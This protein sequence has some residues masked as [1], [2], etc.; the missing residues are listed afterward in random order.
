MEIIADNAL[1]YILTTCEGREH[2]AANIKAQIPEAIVN[3]DDFNDSGKFTSTA[4]FNYQRGWKLAGDSPCVQMDDDI[5]LTSNFKEKI[6]AV[7][8]KYPNDIIQFFSMRKKDI[9]IGT[10]METLSNFM[11]QQCYYLPCGVAAKI[12]EF[13]REF[14]EY[15]E[16]RFCPSDFVISDWGK[17]NKR[18]Y[19]IY[20]PNLVDHMDTVSKIDKRRS[21]KR[22]SKTFKK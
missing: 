14:Y 3:F 16:D 13:S 5:I 19:V 6:T 17:R 2:L 1:K 8:E 22:Q 20:C 4:W 18:T 12:Y 9:D 21:S 10:R 15:T 7:I 11:M